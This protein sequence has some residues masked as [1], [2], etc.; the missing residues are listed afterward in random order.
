M[1]VT[2][3]TRLLTVNLFRKKKDPGRLSVLT[4]FVQIHITKDTEGK[5]AVTHGIWASTVG[6]GGEKAGYSRGESR[7]LRRQI[8]LIRLKDLS[9]S[10]WGGGG[11]GGVGGGGDPA[12]HPTPM[13]ADRRE[14]YLQRKRS[15]EK[16]EDRIPIPTVHGL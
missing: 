9:L 15:Y 5:K 16:N 3:T 13:L 2:L 11:G 1:V 14:K 12:V 10:E 6:D 4:R 7:T 8:I